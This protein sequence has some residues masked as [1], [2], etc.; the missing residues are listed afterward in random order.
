VGVSGWDICPVV[1]LHWNLGLRTKFFKKTQSQ[2]LNSEYWFNSCKDSWFAGMTYWTRARFTVAVLCSDESLQ[3]TQIPSFVFRGRL[4][5]L[6]ADFS[7]VGQNIK[8]LLQFTVVDV[9]PQGLQLSFF[10]AR[11]WN[12][13]VFDMLGFSSNP[14]KPDKLWLLLTFFSWKCLTLKKDCKRYRTYSTLQISSDE[15][16]WPC[17]VQTYLFLFREDFDSNLLFETC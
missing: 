5:N 14:K 16:L 12:S 1:S 9:L 7:I 15:G 6:Q 11:F 2:Q 3:F 17:R 13:G 10:E 8:G 4:R